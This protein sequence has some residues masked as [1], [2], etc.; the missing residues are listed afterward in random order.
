MIELNINNEENIIHFKVVG[1][2]QEGDF[3]TNIRPKVDEHL[4]SNE[5][6]KG[7]F[8][9]GTD[10]QGWSDFNALIEHLNFVKD[11]HRFIKKLAIVGDHLLFSFAP[12]IIGSMVKVDLKHFASAKAEAANEWL[13]AKEL[14]A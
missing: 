13:K 7:V 2:I 3:D 5:S 11:H 10:F 4:K 9:D 6:I 14:A 12:E 8:I 1:K